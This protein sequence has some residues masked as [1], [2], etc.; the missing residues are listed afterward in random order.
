M[1]REPGEGGRLVFD[2]VDDDAVGSEQSVPAHGDGA[3]G[4]GDDDP[5][6][7]GR[8]SGGSVLSDRRMRFLVPVAAVLAVVLGTGL[9]VEGA[10]DGARVER[11]RDVRGGVADVSRPLAETWRWDG[12]VGSPKTEDEWRTIEVAMLGDVLALESEGELVALRPATGEEAWTVALGEDPDCGPLD[13]DGWGRSVAS[14][15]VCL[16]G[17]AGDRT[18]RVVGPEGQ[19][20]ASRRLPAGDTERFGEPRPGPDGSVLRARR[21]GAGPAL[22]LSDAR[23]TDTGECAGTVRDGQGLEVRAEDAVTGEERWRAT[24]PFRPT[25]A[26]QC[27]NWLGVTWDGS[28]N[29]V[30]LAQMID[31]EVFGA[32]IGADL[33]QLYGCGIE[34]ALTRDGV[35][36][37]TEFEPGSGGV[38]S[39]LSGGYAEYSYDD[40]LRTVLYTDDGTLVGE[41]PGSVTDAGV[42][43]GEGPGVLLGMDSG[44]PHLR[45]YELDGTPR[46]DVT[47]RAGGQRFLA[48]VAGTMLV[49]T[50]TGD[51]RGLD[52]ATGDARWVWDSAEGGTGDGYLED[53][54][55]YQT[56]TDGESVLLLTESGSGG[57]A[58]VA[59]DA[60]SGEVVWEQHGDDAVTGGITRGFDRS[61]IAVDGR[62]LEVTPDGV[63]GLG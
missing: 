7:P 60:A 57:A 2:L 31:P 39:L 9:A 26:D 28:A 52:A 58:L 22:D 61:L 62:L 13:S 19:V 48:H 14:A 6:A 33:V 18:A 44:G 63:R 41:I 3:P 20:S 56:F 32:R 17:P 5:G 36:L 50:G 38:G 43:D 11:M 21:A 1:A 24:V 12:A 8:P 15:L 10:R 30:D 29:M 35:L 49:M 37:G 51:V 46:W 55:V 54:F 59:L 23:C 4:P 16:E 27:N 42:T 40:T 47:A 45:A 34:S 53:L 25:R